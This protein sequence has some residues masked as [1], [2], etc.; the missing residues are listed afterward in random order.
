MTL[1]ATPPI[2]A[3]WS[4]DEGGSNFAVYAIEAVV[5][6]ELAFMNSRKGRDLARTTLDLSQYPS[7][8]PYTI[9]FSTMRQTRHGY[10]TQRAIIREEIP[11]R[12]SLQT[13]LQS[14]PPISTSSNSSNSRRGFS[15]STGP[16]T[17]HISKSGAGTGNSS[18][19]TSRRG[20]GVVAGSTSA[21]SVKGGASK[22][23]SV[24]SSSSPL[25]QGG[26]AGA[27]GLCVVCIYVGVKFRLNP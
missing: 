12:K 26:S 22:K 4:W 24:T 1:P 23:S 27:G 19:V 21:R 18:T 15:L 8:L 17:A 3:Y 7:Q 14:S 10:M 16:A 20:G 13:L 2:R 11:N 25:V 6:I 5:D 9:D